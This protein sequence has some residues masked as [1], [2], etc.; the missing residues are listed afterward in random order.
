M[1]ELRTAKAI[2]LTS[3]PGCSFVVDDTPPIAQ[4]QEAQISIV[5]ASITTG[6]KTITE[7]GAFAG[8]NLAGKEVEVTL[9]APEAGTYGIVSN[10]D[11]VLTTDN[12]FGATD[13]GG[14]ACVSRDI[15]QVYLTRD[16]SS[17]IRFIEA[18]AG[19]F[20]K[21]NGQLY[22]DLASPP[23]NGACS[24]TYAPA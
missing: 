20:A 5:A 23:L 12:T 6:L 11:D 9:P 18:N 16:E 17:F 14:V 21:V 1:G 8:I 15:A 2:D 3:F 10:T 4:C 22:T 13:A 7:V 24:D 19:A